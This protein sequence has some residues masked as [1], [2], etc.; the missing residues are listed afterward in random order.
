MRSRTIYVLLFV[1]SFSIMHDTFIS[2][3]HPTDDT[4][5]TQCNESTHMVNSVM[6]IHEI[7][8]MFH[9]LAVMSEKNV[10]FD[11]H[12][13]SNISSSNVFLYTSPYK[14]RSS[15]PPIV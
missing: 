9:F 6:D 3:L 10:F 1:I 5:T 14:K 11:N 8:N 7:H 13:I 15:R 12:H 4:Q 2:L